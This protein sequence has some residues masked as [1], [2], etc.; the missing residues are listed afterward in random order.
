MLDSEWVRTRGC[1]CC[2]GRFAPPLV[3]TS[4]KVNER[5]SQASETK[6]TLLLGPLRVLITHAV[7]KAVTG[8]RRSKG[9]RESAWD[10]NNG[11][12]RMME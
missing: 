8:E 4:E 12:K 11:K 7:G 9:L 2:I 6:V 1:C 10:V 3:S 5:F